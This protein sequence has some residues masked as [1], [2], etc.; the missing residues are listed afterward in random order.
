[1]I[2]CAPRQPHQGTAQGFH[3]QEPDENA[4]SVATKPSSKTPMFRNACIV[5]CSVGR[6]LLL[7]ITGPGTVASPTRTPNNPIFQDTINNPKLV[8]AR[9]ITHVND[10]PIL[11]PS[12]MCFSTTSHS[13]VAVPS[14]TNPACSEQSVSHLCSVQILQRGLFWRKRTI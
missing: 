13:D 5:M 8:P 3:L 9:R 7:K 12:V 6:L 14:F 1:M 2:V 11:F 10:K 4:C